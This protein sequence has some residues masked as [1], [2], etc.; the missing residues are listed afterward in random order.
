MK[1]KIIEGLKYNVEREY[2][3]FDED[4]SDDEVSHEWVK[5]SAV[6]AYGKLLH[7]RPEAIEEME[8]ELWYFMKQLP[9]K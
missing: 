7:F 8:E 5:E 3:K 4:D 2:I 9:L 1:E 6:L